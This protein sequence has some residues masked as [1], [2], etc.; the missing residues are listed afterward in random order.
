MEFMR[1]YPKNCATRS[2]AGGN[3]PAPRRT[4]RIATARFPANIVHNCRASSRPA[5]SPRRRSFKTGAV[6]PHRQRECPLRSAGRSRAI[7][8]AGSFLLRQWR[9]REML[10]IAWRDIAGGAAVAETLQA[11]SD[12][13]DATISRGG[14]GGGAAFAADLRRAA[15]LE[16]AQSPFVVLGME[17]WAAVNSIFPPT[18]I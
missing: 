17:N 9:R 7:R 14:G 8:R 18:S 12:L 1:R 10:R 16:P 2:S 15:A 3:A 5:N 11:V 4:S 6:L 13:A